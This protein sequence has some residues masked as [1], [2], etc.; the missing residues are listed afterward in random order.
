MTEL[1]KHYR[2]AIE[3]LLHY[4]TASV[5][6]QKSLFSIPIVAVLERK[7]GFSYTL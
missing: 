5:V 6:I 4:N 3:P 1:N 7:R 2:G